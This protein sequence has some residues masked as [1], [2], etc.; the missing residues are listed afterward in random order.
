LFILEHATTIEAHID[1]RF[2]FLTL[3]RDSSVPTKLYV[4]AR[5]G[6]L[7]LEGAPKVFNSDSFGL[8]ILTPSGVFKDSYAQVA[9]GRSEQFQ[10]NRNWNRLK[11]DGVLVVDIAPSL[12]DR[13]E[14]WKR[15]GGSSRAFVAISVDRNPGGPGPDSVQSYVGIDFDLQTLVAGFK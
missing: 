15:L 8:G 3:Q 4:T 9:W 12:K 10:S 11:I 13:L 5:F 14:F 1:P 2:E 6:F 7:D